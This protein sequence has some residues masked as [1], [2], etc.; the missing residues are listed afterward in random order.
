MGQYQA[1]IFDLDGTLLDTLGD[2]RASVN[3]ALAQ[4]GYPARTLDEVRRFVGNGVG[5]LVR[6]AVPAG[7][8]EADA[9]RCLELF[10]AHYADHCRDLTVPY[11]GIP[12]LLDALH[13]AGVPAAVVSNKFD[14]AVKELCAHYFPGRIGAAVGESAEVARKPA[15]DAVFRAAEELG[16]PLSSMVY[17]GD[18]DVDIQTAKNAGVPCISVTWGFRDR[19]FLEQAGGT[20]FADAPTDILP[21]LGL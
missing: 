6:R 9:A 14:A 4:L 20:V 10:R 16:V 11:P 18:S 3:Y 2:L 5:L 1:V 15:P 12:A 8:P 17:V 7:T 21:L 19:A 13:A